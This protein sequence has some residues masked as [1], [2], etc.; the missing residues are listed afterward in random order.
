MARA[1]LSDITPTQIMFDS[2]S[3]TEEYEWQ[4]E[5]VTIGSAAYCY[6]GSM[7]MCSNTTTCK[8]DYKKRQAAWNIFVAWKGLVAAKK[9]YAGDKMWS[10]TKYEI[11]KGKKEKVTMYRWAS[12]VGH[13]D[14]VTQFTCENAANEIIKYAFAPTPNEICNQY[15]SCSLQAPLFSTADILTYW[16]HV[17]TFGQINVID[18]IEYD[19]RY[20]KEFVYVYLSRDQLSNLFMRVAEFYKKRWRDSEY[21]DEHYLSNQV[22]FE[23]LAAIVDRKQDG[24][25][26]AKKLII[27]PGQIRVDDLDETFDFPPFNREE[28]Q[29]GGSFSVYYS[30]LNK[31]ILKYRPPQTHN[32]RFW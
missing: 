24:K 28:Q 13:W 22:K 14:A 12:W 27:G 21:D 26:V 5:I 11:V 10:Y 30:I 8:R 31:E 1:I 20:I 15:L 2:D 23:D 4:D 9:N 17:Q 6:C 18:N 25:Y 19:N 29:I 7:I 16:Y 3:D 32:L